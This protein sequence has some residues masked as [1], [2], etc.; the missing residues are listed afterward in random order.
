VKW[1][2]AIVAAGLLAGLLLSPKL[3]LSTRIYPQTPVWSALR[4]IPAPFDYALYGA[5][6]LAVIA[7][8]VTPKITP[9]LLALSPV[10]VAFD[11]SRLQPGSSSTASCSLR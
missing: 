8:A 11:Q 7:A 4:P 6:L 5:L 10:M 3:W 2:R 9:I 1:L